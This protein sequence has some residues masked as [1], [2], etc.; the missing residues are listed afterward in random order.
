MILNK[1]LKAKLEDFFFGK[2]IKL[3]EV[4]LFE[5]IFQLEV[6][7]ELIRI[8]FKQDLDIMDVFDVLEYIFVFFVY[9]R[10]NKD[11]FKSWFGSF[12]LVV[13]IEVNIF[14]RGLK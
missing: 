6:D 7:K 3:S 14:M 9:I 11:R 10:V 1:I 12:G 5:F 4:E 2:L 8:I 13:I